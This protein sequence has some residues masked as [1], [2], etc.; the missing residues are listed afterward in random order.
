MTNRYFICAWWP[1]DDDGT[2][3]IDFDPLTGPIKPE[4]GRTYTVK[5]GDACTYRIYFYDFGYNW[6]TFLEMRRACKSIELSIAEDEVEDEVEALR[7][8]HGK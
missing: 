5:V 4:C 7:G 6:P 2:L 3:A 1:E 8:A